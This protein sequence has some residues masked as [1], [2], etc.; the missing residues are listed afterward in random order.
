MAGALRDACNEETWGTFM[1]RFRPAAILAATILIATSSAAQ[2]FPSK[3]VRIVVP[4]PA[5]GSFDSMSRLLANR[6]QLGQSVIIENRPGGGT[7]I[8]TEYVSR[9]PPDGHTILCI[10]PSFTMLSA[11]RSKLPFDT[12]RDFRAL[13]LAMG[14][15]MVVAVNSSLP[16]KTMKD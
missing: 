1:R 11:L 4:F 8:G 6:M 14:L 5:G 10:G 2:E 16:V 7:V 3:P 15:N 13:A 9:L 12:D